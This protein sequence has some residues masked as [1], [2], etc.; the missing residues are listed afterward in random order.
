MFF[1]SALIAPFETLNSQAISALKAH[2]TAETAITASERTACFGRAPPLLGDD[3][4]VRLVMT[5][6]AEPAP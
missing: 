4:V 1:G 5:H 3:T 2:R 6:S